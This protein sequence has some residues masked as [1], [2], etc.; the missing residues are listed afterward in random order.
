MAA[1][2]GRGGAAG[3]RGRGRAPGRGALPGGA[4]GGGGAPR[5][6]PGNGGVPRA[7]EG[8]WAL[9]SLPTLMAL[10][11]TLLHGVPARPTAAGQDSGFPPATPPSHLLPLLAREQTN[12][13][14]E[15]QGWLSRSQHLGEGGQGRQTASARARGAT[16]PPQTTPP[17]WG[18]PP[19]SRTGQ[20]G[21]KE[22]INRSK[23]AGTGGSPLRQGTQ[24]PAPESRQGRAGWGASGGAPV[25]GEG[26]GWGKHPGPPGRAAALRGAGEGAVPGGQASSPRPCGTQSSDRHKISSEAARPSPPPLQLP[27]RARGQGQELS[28]SLSHTDSDRDT[29]G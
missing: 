4:E 24:A 13:V 26:A 22:P 12:H 3:T 11:S 14:V 23:F 16:E 25:P 1:G 15:L 29:P 9:P 19:R 6:L 8:L 18:T 21:E 17:A 28:V 2:G 20:Q 10:I 27:A 7:Q 5:I